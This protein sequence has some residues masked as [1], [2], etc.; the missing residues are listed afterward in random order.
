MI[1]YL[2]GAPIDLIVYDVQR[3]SIIPEHTQPV[4]VRTTIGYKGDS[5][6][7]FCMIYNHRF[8]SKYPSSWSRSIES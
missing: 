7:Q 8:S 2:T 6:Y 4:A 1:L 5:I 3:I